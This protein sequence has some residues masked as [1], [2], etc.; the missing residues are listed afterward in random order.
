[1]LCF[2]STVQ[3]YHEEKERISGIIQSREIRMSRIK[4]DNLGH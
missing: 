3:I 1:M 4:E 2:L